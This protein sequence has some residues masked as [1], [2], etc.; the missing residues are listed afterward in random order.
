MLKLFNEFLIGGVRPPSEFSEGI[1]TLIPK[2]GDTKDLNNSRP[3][4]LL[5]CDQKIFTKILAIRTQ[6]F[7]GEIIGEGQTACIN[8]GS[9][10]YNL[11]HIRNILVKAN[12]SKK[13]KL[14]L[15]SIDMAN[16][17]DSVNH[18]LL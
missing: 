18:Q 15:L 11:E 16:A 13:F 2:A 10:I 12:R 14:A 1:I 5:N 9:C 8:K 6:A 17:F 4:S 3:I 7:L